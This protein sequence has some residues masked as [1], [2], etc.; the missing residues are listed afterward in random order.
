MILLAVAH[1][2][3]DNLRDLRVLVDHVKDSDALLLIL[4]KEVLRRPW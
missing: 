1:A 2:D 3:S 4:S